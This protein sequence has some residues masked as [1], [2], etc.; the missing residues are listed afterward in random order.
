MEKSTALTCGTIGV[1]TAST[2]ARKIRIFFFITLLTS[3]FGN[4]FALHPIFIG[5][6]LNNLIRTMRLDRALAVEHHLARRATADLRLTI[7][8]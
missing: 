5:K 6:A 7:N 3:S 2:T 1:L 8:Q 4:L